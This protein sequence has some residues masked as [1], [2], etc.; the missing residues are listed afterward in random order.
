[1]HILAWI[2][3]LLSILAIL[4]YTR[5]ENY[6]NKFSSE[7]P[8]LTKRQ[9][10]RELDALSQERLYQLLTAYSSKN[11]DENNVSSSHSG[12]KKRTKE[13][14]AQGNLEITKE[15]EKNQNTTKPQEALYLDLVPH[16]ARLNLQV[17]L[18]DI[19]TTKQD[20]KDRVVV[21]KEIFSSLLRMLYGDFTFFNAIP[22]AEHQ[23]IEQ[24]L[25]KL[26]NENELINN[27][28]SLAT[29]KF[30]D[31]RIQD[32]F[33]RILKGDKQ[34]VGPNKKGYPSLLELVIYEPKR[35]KFEINVHHAPETLL[36]AIFNDQQV[37]KEIVL[38][39]QSLHDAGAEQSKKGNR[40]T[41]LYLDEEKVE[42]LLRSSGKS[43]DR[44]KGLLDFSTR[45]PTSSELL[46]T[47]YLE[48]YSSKEAFK[49]KLKT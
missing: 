20:K 5:M 29:L 26:N 16:N 19:K 9:A 2:L 18:S 6:L 44:Y 7:S 21:F 11:S 42:A 45:K 34:Q 30:E 41:K 12:G 32:L 4:S 36:A 14:V 13:K 31:S 39:R 33:F 27:S 8:Y 46:S 38:L 23:I 35:R 40:R 48:V 43:L 10:E 1:M 47:L 17:L 28:E 49:K 3:G 25:L 22:N 37:A 15:Y 24:L